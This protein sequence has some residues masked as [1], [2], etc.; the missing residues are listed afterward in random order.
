MR[1]DEARHDG[2]LRQVDRLGAGRDVRLNALDAARLDDDDEVGSNLAGGDVEQSARFDR[3]RAR[4]ITSLRCRAQRRRH[5][6]CAQRGHETDC[7]RYLGRGSDLVSC[8]SGQVIAMT[9]SGLPLPCTI[10]SGAA[11]TTAPVAGS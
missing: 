9:R 6:E 10:L 8:T 4:R 7:H 2:V 11:I 3:E 1:I 5:H